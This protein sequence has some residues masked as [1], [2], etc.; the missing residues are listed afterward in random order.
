MSAALLPALCAGQVV[1]VSL[2][3]QQIHL[4]SCRAKAGI[5]LYLE[6]CKKL[7]AGWSRLGMVCF[8][9]AILLL[10]SG[11]GTLGCCEV[12]RQRWNTQVS[13][14]HPLPLCLALFLAS[15]VIWISNLSRRGLFLLS[16]TDSMLML[17]TWLGCVA[18]PMTLVR[19]FGKILKQ[20][21][22]DPGGEHVR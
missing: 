6:L 18:L 11:L 13:L 9:L 17:V 10:S 20:V 8:A 2:E 19:Y 16:C 1:G 21:Q 15:S 14:L 7:Q 12:H 4:F 5:Q 22:T 3:V